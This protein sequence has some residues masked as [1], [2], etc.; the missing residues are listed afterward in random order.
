M[1]QGLS[2]NSNYDSDFSKK[3]IATL[4][5]VGTPHSGTFDDETKVEFNNQGEV[6]FQG[7]R[8]GVPGAGIE[9]CRAITCYQTGS[10]SSTNL[11][12][13]TDEG[14]EANK[15]LYGIKDTSG[16]I[17]YDLYKKLNSYPNIK[18]QI[19]IGLVAEKV[20]IEKTGQD[21]YKIKYDLMDDESFANSGSGDRL[22]SVF[23]QRLLPDDD[24]KDLNDIYRSLNINEHVLGFEKL[25]ND[26]F[27]RGGDDFYFYK[28]K[29]GALIN[30]DWTI[31]KYREGVSF[32]DLSIDFTLGHNHRTGQYDY[33]YKSYNITDPYASN[34]KIKNIYGTR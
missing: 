17:V 22:I 1:I 18:T 27:I 29:E 10:D 32:L 20:K 19:L 31:D 24:G 16:F 8:N 15:R 21:K 26:D 23:G 11:G 5:T 2:T 34:E 7:G 12:L 9:L 28:F 30:D 13:S 6:I 25:F 4:T 14:L 33:S 3:Y